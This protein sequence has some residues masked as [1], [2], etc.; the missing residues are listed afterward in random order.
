MS[1]KILSGSENNVPHKKWPKRI[2]VLV[3]L[4]VVL[5]GVWA[6][7][8]YRQKF[9]ASGLIDGFFNKTCNASMKLPVG[10]SKIPAL[11]KSTYGKDYPGLQTVSAYSVDLD[12]YAASWKL[13][14]N[15]DALLANYKAKL[16][17]IISSIRTMYGEPFQNHQVTVVIVPN[18]QDNYEYNEWYTANMSGQYRP[19]LN[20]IMYSEWAASDPTAFIHEIIHSFNQGTI[21]SDAYEEGLVESAAVRVTQSLQLPLRPQHAFDTD[22]RPDLSVLMGYFR[23]SD[24]SDTTNNRYDAAAKFFSS[25]YDKDHNFYKTF[26]TNLKNSLYFNDIIADSKKFVADRLIGGSI[27]GY[28]M[29]EDKYDVFHPYLADIQKVLLKSLPTAISTSLTSS[30]M[31]LRPFQN[32][33]PAQS[34]N[35]NPE[36]NLYNDLAFYPDTDQLRVYSSYKRN[37]LMEIF[38]EYY[39]QFNAQDEN[40]T[41]YINMDKIRGFS[42]N[43]A[44]DD[45]SVSSKLT[46]LL[47]TAPDQT[48]IDL[49]PQ[50]VAS[51]RTPDTYRFSFPS[52][53][54]LSNPKD[55]NSACLDS[56]GQLQSNESSDNEITSYSSAKMRDDAKLPAD[57]TGNVKVTVSSSKK[58]WE[59]RRKRGS[60]SLLPWTT[61]VW[62]DGFTA[63]PKYIS[64]LTIS[65]VTFANGKISSVAPGSGGLEK[66]TAPTVATAAASSVTTTSAVLN[67]SVATTRT[68]S[69]LEWGFKYGISE[70][71]L[72][73]SVFV[74]NRPDRNGQFST[75]ISGLKAG[76]KY[77]FE[78]FA[79]NH[80]GIGYGLPALNFT[81]LAATPP[82]TTTPPPTTTNTTTNTT[83]SQ[84]Q[85]SAYLIAP[86][87]PIAPI[88]D[89]VTTTIKDTAR[90][91]FTSLFYA[92]GNQKIVKRGF[93][94]GPLGGDGS[95]VNTY[96]RGDFGFGSGQ[97]SKTA[98]L[99]ANSKYWVQAYAE[100]STGVKTVGKTLMSFQMTCVLPTVSTDNMKNI[101]KTSAIPLGKINSI[102]SAP[103]IKR[104]FQWRVSQADTRIESSD[105]TAGNTAFTIGQYEYTK[106]T[107]MS[108]LKPNTKYL[109]RAHVESACGDNYGT[110]KTFSTQR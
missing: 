91:T 63:S 95:F 54:V 76:T 1:S 55:I 21:I 24:N 11:L 80:A 38:Y 17:S 35:I 29:Y 106:P 77:Y 33:T 56:K 89:Q 79:S 49:E 66:Q 60:T 41:N 8:I 5:V 85:L 4:V 82:A 70:K 6:A 74:T 20:L 65:T 88:I 107:T 102:G 51:D 93:L 37:D 44:T 58:I 90:V 13:I 62:P 26:R 69:A 71:A 81:T 28:L 2:L 12:T 27:C 10:T 94:Y 92:A 59:I 15:G 48:V 52:C 86:T 110:W 18:L 87:A 31:T 47:E 105:D 30:D 99:K 25:I 32:Y 22:N 50:V 83:P 46:K 43:I 57:F 23:T 73:N 16:P 84:S 9:Q 97:F 68:G 78:A 64:V 7:S 42:G 103:I 36:N 19:D 39:K 40:Q 75:I 14:P 109:I 67:G 53:T 72:D 101:T 104:G 3:L 96:D 100:S 98:T 45:N 61:I 108:G 34:I